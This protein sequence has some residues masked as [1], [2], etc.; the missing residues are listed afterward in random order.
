[1]VADNDVGTGMSAWH[2]YCG[3]PTGLFKLC[4]FLL[5]FTC[6]M[7]LRLNFT[8]GYEYIHIDTD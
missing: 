6:K 1:M 5:G 7:G 2:V 3:H 4:S 8:T